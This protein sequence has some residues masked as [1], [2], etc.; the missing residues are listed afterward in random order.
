VIARRALTNGD[1]EQAIQNY[2]G[3]LAVG[4]DAASEAEALLGLA[5]SY[6]AAGQSAAAIQTFHNFRVRYPT[7]PRL[8][9]AWYGEG[10]AYET[11]N[12]WSEAQEAY[13]SS[14]KAG[15]VITPYIYARLGDANRQLGQTAA[16]SFYKAALQGHLDLKLAFSLMERIAEMYLD[17]GNYMEAVAWYDRILEQAVQDDYRAKIEYLAAE[18]LAAAGLKDE[19]WA[20]H[21]IIISRYPRSAYAHPALRQL[22]ENNLPVD[23][24]QRGLVD[25]YAEAYEAAIAALTRYAAQPEHSGDAH[26][27]LGLSYRALG[28]YEQAQREFDL[29]LINHPEN[30][31]LDETRLEKA[32]TMVRAGDVQAGLEAY[33]RFV[34]ERPDSPQAPEA[35][36]RIAELEEKADRPLEAAAAYLELARQYPSHEQALFSRFAAGF[37]HYRLGSYATA[38]DIWAP[39]ADT[40]HLPEIRARALFWLGKAHQAVG[41]DQAAARA[42]AEAATLRPTGY[43]GQR[44]AEL[45]QTPA[46]PTSTSTP[47]VSSQPLFFVADEALEQTM[48]ERWLRTWAKLPEDKNRSHALSSL[49]PLIADDPEWRWGVALAEYGLADEGITVLDTICKRFWNNPVALYQMALAFRDLRCYRLSILCAER[50]LALAPPSAQTTAPRFVLRLIY[51]TYFAELVLN[52]AKANGLDPLL[53]FALIRQESLFE[54]QATSWAGAGGLTQVMPTT[55]T[56]IAERLPWPGFTTADLYRPLVNIK[57]GAWYLA[58]QLRAFDQ[59]LRLATIAYNAGPGRMASWLKLTTDRDLLVEILP[60]TE[61][62]VYARQVYAF[63]RQYQAL[64]RK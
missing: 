52:E 29:L 64:Y 14:L 57:F 11:L 15:A 25:Y 3:A 49:D 43:Y 35:L 37:W 40:N 23:E 12:R 21:R 27:Y 45:L 38:L 41:D 13:T 2:K 42:W 36:L 33:R 1:F 47:V 4:L 10:Q 59:D 63:Y 51:P 32:Q 50:L 56:W 20:R 48:A 5:Q 61:P 18:A 8:P 7:D 30:A 26:Y 24:F 39:L 28:Q 53:L 16:I 34:M 62:Q 54:S 46:Q 31:R 58:A 19:A 22:V 17:Q 55:G 9:L 60:L 6:L 44:A